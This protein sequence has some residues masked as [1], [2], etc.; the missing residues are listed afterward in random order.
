[1]GIRDKP[2]AWIPLQKG[3]AERLVGSRLLTRN[4]RVHFFTPSGPN[5]LR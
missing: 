5:C 3:F 1:M 2:N 4:R